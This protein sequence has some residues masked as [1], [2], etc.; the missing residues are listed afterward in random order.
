MGPF[1]GP[2][3]SIMAVCVEPH[4]KVNLH[5]YPGLNL[6]PLLFVLSVFTMI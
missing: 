1:G 6:G 2:V 5:S 4:F 3:L